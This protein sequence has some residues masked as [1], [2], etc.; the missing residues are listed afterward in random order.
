MSGPMWLSTLPIVINVSADVSVE[1]SMS[2][3]SAIL[4]MH[5]DTK[6]LHQVICSMLNILTNDHIK[7]SILKSFK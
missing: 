3:L 4:N 2:P 5:L 1:V 7:S 6:M